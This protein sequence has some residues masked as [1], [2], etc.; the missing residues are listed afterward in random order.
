MP[1]LS[2]GE[3][4]AGGISN[5]EVCSI[6]RHCCN[7]ASSMGYVGSWPLPHFDEMYEEYVS[8][9]FEKRGKEFEK[10]LLREFDVERGDRPELYGF[11]RELDFFNQ[12]MELHLSFVFKGSVLNPPVKGVW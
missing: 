5:E 2:V 8:R 9:E 11:S 7:S 12:L 3:Y 1:N 6:Y 10:Q 4:K